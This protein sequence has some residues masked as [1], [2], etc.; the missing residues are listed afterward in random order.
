MSEFIK[1]VRGDLLAYDAKVRCHQVNCR[2][3]MGA[4]LAKQVK[5]KYPEAYEQYKALCDQFGSSLLGH[6][7]FV[8]CHD[9]TVIAN[10]FAQD[11]YGTDAVQ[12]VMGAL[13]DCLSQV[14]NF[15]F[16]IDAKPA[17]PKL[18]GC[19]L[20]GGNWDDVSKLIA[21]YFDFKSAG[22]TIVEYTPNETIPAPAEKPK[23]DVPAAEPEPKADEPGTETG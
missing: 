20:A 4:G 11:G 16:R 17:F 6:T 5:E 18:M 14:A 3:V 9:G 22:C 15:C 2:G 1:E 13:D 7:Q 10:L 21:Q 8:I 19:G 12:T 23:V